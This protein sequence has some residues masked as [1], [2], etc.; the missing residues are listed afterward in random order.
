MCTFHTHQSQESVVNVGQNAIWLYLWQL[1]VW[2]EK[3]SGAGYIELLISSKPNLMQ[4]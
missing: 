4:F 1:I 3:K 2:I